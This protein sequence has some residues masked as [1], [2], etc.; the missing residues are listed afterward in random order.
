VSA[1]IISVVIVYLLVTVAIGIWATRRTKNTADYFIAGRSLGMFVV[2]MA[3]FTSVQSG[4][5]VLGGT[6]LTFDR[7]LGGFVAAIGFAAPLG[8]ALAWF[9]AAKRMWK[10]GSLGE[11]YTLGDVVEKRY[12]SKGVRGWIGFA[13]ALGVIGYLGVQVQATGFVMASVFGISTTTGAIL[14]LAILGA[15]AVGGGIIAGVYTDLVQGVI[16][17]GVSVAVLFFAVSAGGGVQSMTETLQAED[18]ALASP[19]GTLSMLTIACYFLLFSIG[20]AGQPH[21][22]TK[23]LMTRS[24]QELKWGAFTSGVA[25]LMTMLLVASVGLAALA[26]SF[27]GQFPQLD[28]PDQAL[29]TFLTEF[30]PALL[31]GLALAGILAA[32][33]STGDAFLNLGAQSLIRD[34]P[35]TFDYQVRNELLWSRVSVAALLVL[36]LLFS[37]YLDTL[38]ALLGVFGWG[39]FAA[40]I[41][42][43]VV[44]GLVWPRATRQGAIACIIVSLAINFVL[45]IGAIYGFAPLPEGLVNGAFALVVSI[46]V[47][48]GVSLATQPAEDKIAPEVRKVLD[49]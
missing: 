30:T 49:G 28:S 32:I 14:G 31:A 8:F 12:D 36:S 24:T 9:L 19:F 20:A 37:L 26:L 27:Q 47:F 48:I 34:L 10:L 38:V 22:L 6:G 4:F 25:Y 13:V 18:A 44:L 39:T 5:G 17:V 2:A 42:P 11:V 46:I 21:L 45:E 7:G 29:P 43:A 16:M 15:Y 1:T 23:F 40:A 33:M 35:R 3:V 41:F